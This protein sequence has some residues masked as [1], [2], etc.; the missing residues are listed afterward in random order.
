M[1]RLRFVL[2]SVLLGTVLAVSRFV[3]RRV[4]LGIGSLF[5]FLGY[6]L[7]RRHRRIAE[8]NLDLAFGETLSA[9]DRTRIVRACW[10]HY[11]RMIL[12]AFAFPRFTADSVGDTIHY[13]GLDHVREAYRRGKGVLVFSAHFGNWEL[14]ALMQAHLGMPMHLIT[15]PLDN[16]ALEHMLARYRG[17][18][19][20]VIVH[21]RSAVREM[22][23]ALRTGG[24]VAIVI[25]QDA[26]EGGV[27]VPFFGHLASTTPTLAL[28][29]LRTGAEVVPCFSIP[30]D[31]G[32]YRIVYEKPVEIRDTGD[33]DADVERITAEC[34]AIIERWVRKHPELWLW[35]HRRWKTRPPEVGDAS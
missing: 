7:D 12:D 5:G 21:K 14:T 15:R 10:R 2:E 18:S 30:L 25:D 28:V 22:I 9:E 17:L 19:G 13:E 4:M 27:F 1:R 8:D 31:D 35:M 11:G 20:N 29:A 24:G 3:P 26:R 6:H 33:R 34:T 32:S 23:K 16:Q